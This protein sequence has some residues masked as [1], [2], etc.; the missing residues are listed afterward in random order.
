M[1]AI[2]MQR[3]GRKGH[4]QFRL[5]VQDSRRTPT[6]GN[7]VYLLG[8]YNP[9]SKEVKLEKEKVSFYLSNGAQ[10]SPTVVKLLK[11]EGVKLPKWVDQP[12]KKVSKIKN[13]DK[14]RRNRPPEEKA[15]EPKAEPAAS[16]PSKDGAVDGAESAATNEVPAEA[17]NEAPASNDK[18]DQPADQAESSQ[19]DP[20]EPAEQAAPE[21]TTD[22]K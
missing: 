1:L 19:A 12:V 10:P 3:T 6:S 16:E 2:R 17:S 18:V 13:T 15:S 4:A 9:H 5:V 21:P 20:T 8:Y 11:K 7:V 22:S 14:L